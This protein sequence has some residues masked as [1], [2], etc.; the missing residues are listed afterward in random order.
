MP[1]T[2]LG[3]PGS[4][5]PIEGR[6]VNSLL[7]SYCPSFLPAMFMCTPFSTKNSNGV[8]TNVYTHQ[9]QTCAHLRTVMREASEV[10]P[11]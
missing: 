3:L 1:T 8:T 4:D 2:L 5:L 11:C 10:P 6:A 9:Q 7:L